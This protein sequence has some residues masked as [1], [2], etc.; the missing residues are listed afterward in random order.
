MKKPHAFQ[1][2]TRTH[3]NGAVEHVRVCGQCGLEDDPETDLVDCPECELH[4]EECK[5]MSEG[6]WGN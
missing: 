6:G 4:A 1:F 3:E 5:N 2:V